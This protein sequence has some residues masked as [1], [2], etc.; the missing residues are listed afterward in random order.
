M[1]GKRRTKVARCATRQNVSSAR[2]DKVALRN[3]SGVRGA[4]TRAGKTSYHTDV[5]IRS[6]AAIASVSLSYR[7]RALLWALERRR[8][9]LVCTY[10]A[11]HKPTLGH[12][13]GREGGS[14]YPWIPVTV[15]RTLWSPLEP[16]DFITVTL[17]IDTPFSRE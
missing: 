5:V 14:T 3:T 13:D 1:K 4:R 9:I 12:R 7:A 8:A 10:I 16:G 11:R 6:Q 17:S 2:R 15:S